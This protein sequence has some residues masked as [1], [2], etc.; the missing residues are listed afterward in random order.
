MYGRNHFVSG[1]GNCWAV[2]VVLGGDGVP[3]YW[4]K[5]PGKLEEEACAGMYS[6]RLIIIEEYE[7]DTAT[8]EWWPT[9]HV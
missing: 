8:Q 3:F 5:I 1:F 2:L 4:R 9:T 7:L 6:H